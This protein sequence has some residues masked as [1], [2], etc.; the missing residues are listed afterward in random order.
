MNLNIRS[1]FLK[2]YTFS[3]LLIISILIG[4]LLGFFLK[5]NAIRLKPLGDI[6]LNLLFTAVVPLV[7]FSISSAVAGMIDGKRLGKI[8]SLM[9]LTFIATGIISSTIMVIAVKIYPPTLGL[10]IHLKSDMPLEQLKVSDQIVKA[11]S[12]TDFSD[13]LSKKNML[14]LIIF[15]LLV[16]LATSAVKEK[17]KPFA[18][19]LNSGSEVM[20]KVIEYIMCYAPVGLCAY[21][22]Y[23]VGVF[24]PQLLGSYLRA[25]ALYYPVSMVYFFVGFSFYAYL[26]GQWKGIKIFW[27]NI[28]PPALTAFAT[29]SSMATIPSNL[30]A[31]NTIGI[32]KDVSEVVIPIGATIHMDGSCLS[33]I[34]KIAVLFGLFHMN[35]SGAG[36]MVMAI[37]IALLSGTVMAGIP[38]GGFI[39]EVLIVTLYGFPMETLPIISMIGT[40]VDPPATAINA[41]GD[42]VCSMLIARM[43]GGKNWIKPY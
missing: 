4:S 31:A 25:V 36:T 22:A 33:A 19:F 14:A 35:F 43:M 6:F 2:N 1:N 32:P 27:T 26:A 17:G 18:Q 29:G 38:G 21:F 8:L 42:N 15:S 11:F 13:L 3:F 24:G 9:L 12:V 23:L 37:G 16:G 5:E 7:F 30:E 10:D 34:L 39:G 40:L 20:L 41:I 28:I